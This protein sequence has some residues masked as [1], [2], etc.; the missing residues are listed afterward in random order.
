MFLTFGMNGESNVASF[1]TDVDTWLELDGCD[2]STRKSRGIAK[3]AT[4]P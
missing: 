3:R 4:G 1:M 2:P